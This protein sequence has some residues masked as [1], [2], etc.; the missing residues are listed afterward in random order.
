[1][2]TISQIQQM[3]DDQGFDPHGI[4]GVMGRQ[5]WAAAFCFVAKAQLGDVGLALADGMMTG[6]FAKWGV[7]TGLRAAHMMGQ[8][9]AETGGFRTFVENLNYSAAG[10]LKTFP[11]HYTPT[12]AAKHARN[13]VAIANHVYANRAG[14]GS[15]ASGD[16]WRFRGRGPTQLTFRS[17]YASVGKAI[18]EDLVSNPDA[19]DDP[20]IGMWIMGSYWNHLGLNTWADKDDVGAVSRGI[21]LGNPTAAGTPNGMPARQ[22]YTARAKA[23]FL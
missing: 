12:L 23:L 5:T 8:A 22:S 20:A 11:T 17:N 13:P 4:D 19:A 10:L 9:G 2:K 16:G 18:G 7:T 15:E 21:N 14:N 6:P 3:L 1:M